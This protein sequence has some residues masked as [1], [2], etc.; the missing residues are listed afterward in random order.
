MKKTE[1]K[2]QMKQKN[3]NS[4]LKDNL[5]SLIWVLAL[6]FA[7]NAFLTRT[8]NAADTAKPAKADVTKFDASKG[9]R[10]VS[11]QIEHAK[12]G[13]NF[14]PSEVKAKVGEK[15]DFQI[16]VTAKD[17][18]PTHGFSIP[19]LKVTDVVERA[20]DKKTDKPE[21]SHIHL[22]I[23]PDMVGKHEI[24]CQLHPAH[25]HGVLII[26]PASSQ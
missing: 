13:F 11:I 4:N 21:I 25:K 5:K 7:A 12:D 24:I 18:A 19:D 6:A 17:G 16:S 14:V 8:V 23:T 3:Q 2:T 9:E 26:E 10:V 22:T 20:I 1:M 15:I